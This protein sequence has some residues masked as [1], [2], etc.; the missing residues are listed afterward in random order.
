[1]G[2]ESELRAD[3]SL[4]TATEVL[5]KACFNRQEVQ[6]FRDQRGLG[7]TGS[8]DANWPWDCRRPR[9]FS[10]AGLCRESLRGGQGVEG[11]SHTCLST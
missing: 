6:D 2:S 8:R 11:V 9:G 10:C 4:Y 5:S 7:N 1:M 3:G